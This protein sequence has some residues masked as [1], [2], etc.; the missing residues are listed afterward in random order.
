M[1]FNSIPGVY[2]LATSSTCSCDSQNHLQAPLGGGG[3]M[4]GQN[5]T[6]LATT[7]LG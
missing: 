7:D 1:L 6:Q 5:C 2:L 4:E 3:G